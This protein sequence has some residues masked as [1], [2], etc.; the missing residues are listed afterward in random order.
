[1]DICGNQI[2][3]LGHS[4]FLITSFE[5]KNL[6][7]DPYKISE[8]LPK[9]DIILITHSHYDHCSL[10]D[11]SKIVRKGTIICV[12]A[13]AQSKITKLENIEMQILELGDIIE[14]GKIKVE[15][16]PSYTIN[17]KF[18][19][20][21][22]NWFGFIIKI[23]DLILY[24]AGDCDKIPEMEKLTGYGKK[25]NTFVCMLPVSGQYVMDYEEAF[26]VAEM[27]N[28]SYV[29]PIHYGAGVV[30]TIEDANKFVE[31]C[32]KIGLNAIILEK[33]NGKN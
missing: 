19:P 29:F 8:G 32:K 14:F 12:P 30:G 28:P 2:Y 11:I 16:F 18:H 4:G 9:A 27:L 7:I 20:K 26:D 13:D 15:T 23:R 3:F 31:R 22:E 10:E 6:Y 17:K 1:M 33:Y 25:E 5:G 24:H 21:S